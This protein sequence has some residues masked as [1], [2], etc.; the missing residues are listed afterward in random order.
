MKLLQKLMV[1]TI[2]LKLVVIVLSLFK[3]QAD[4]FRLF[5][6]LVDIGLYYVIFNLAGK[7]KD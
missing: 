4:W 6:D 5:D 2:A 3:G 7:V 1:A